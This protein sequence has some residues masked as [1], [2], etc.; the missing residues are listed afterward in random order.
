M[1]RPLQLVSSAVLLFDLCTLSA[2]IALAQKPNPNSDDLPAVVLA[3]LEAYKAK[4]PEEAV[5]TWLKGSP[6]E[7]S[8]DALNQSTNLL[9]IQDYYG[10]YL[11]FE[12]LPTRV[13]SA[14]TKVIYM[15]LDY[16]KGP[17]FANFMVSHAQ[18]AWIMTSFIFNTQE[19][20]VFPSH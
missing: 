10:A 3:G 16:D 11:G 20:A 12:L 7:T 19:E 2:N 15:V 9:Q 8:R 14:K 17:F 4:G 6:I 5:K 18:Q 1:R 13:I